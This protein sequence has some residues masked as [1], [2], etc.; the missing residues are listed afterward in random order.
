MNVDETSSG[1]EM[2]ALRELF[3]AASDL[4]PQQRSAFL[5]KK[6]PDV[7]LRRRVDA[8]LASHD[9]GENFLSTPAADLTLLHTFAAKQPVAEAGPDPFI[10]FMLGQYRITALLGSGGM[11]IVYRAQQNATQRPV[12]IKVIRSAFADSGLLRRF[13]QE[14]LVLGRLK[15]PGIAQIYE[16]GTSE[17]PNGPQ[18]FFAMELVRG[19]SLTDYAEQH[20]LQLKQRLDLF[21][22]ICDAVHYAHQQGV[23]HRDLKP[24]NIL[25]DASGQP[26]ILDFGVA[27]LTNADAKAT[28]QT[29]V[30]QVVGTL[31]YMSPEQVNA[32][33]GQIDAR[34]DVYSLGVILYQL[35][36]G[37]LPYDLSKQ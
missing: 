37:R 34:S 35:V 15:H 20:D 36:S 4:P 29:T 2:E 28:R 10:N 22:R 7:A 16:A 31:Q 6:C 13:R 12:A 3:D 23:V 5:E 30:G 17:G 8:L 9:Q 27:R 1:R 14:S 25:V 32:D 33:P 11:G 19:E 18:S 24:A 21:A 26:K